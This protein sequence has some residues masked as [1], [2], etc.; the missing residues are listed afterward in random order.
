[1]FGTTQRD[2]ALSATYEKRAEQR[3]KS[4]NRWSRR[5]RYL[6]GERERIRERVIAGMARARAQGK[7]VGRPR[8]KVTDADLTSVGSLSVREAAARLG[9][10]KSLV[11]AWRKA[12][13]AVAPRS[14]GT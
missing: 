5:R 1:M 4:R 6:K 11:A 14:P 2:W 13:N 7:N 12:I 3:Q 10:S 9:V 8:V